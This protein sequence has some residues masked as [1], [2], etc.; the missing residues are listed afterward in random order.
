VKLAVVVQRYGHGING[1]AELHARYVAE[2]LSHHAE[3]D[4]LT[5][6]ASDYITWRNERGPASEQINGVP[7]RRF[8]V[9]HERDLLTFSRHSS[10]VFEQP[11]SLADELRW[12]DAEGPTSPSLVSHIAAHAITYDFCL[13]FSYRYYQAYHGAR[14]APGRAVLVP[15]AERDPAVGLGLFQPIFRGV[16]ALMYN[17]PEEQ[18][19]IQ[20]VSGNYEVPSVVVGVGSDVPADAQPDRFRQKYRIEGRFALYVGRIDE[21]KGCRE[22][23]EL[24]E[25]YLRGR[26][27]RLSLV[28]VGQTLLPI[29]DHPCIRHLGFLDDRD[30]FDAMAAA[31]LLIVPSYFESLSMV[32]LEAWA[33]GRPV[34]ANGRCDVLKGQIMRSQAGLYYESGE[35]FLAALRSL[36]KSERFRGVFGANGRKFF[37]QHY[38]WGVIERKYLDLLQRL[39]DEPARVAMDPLPGWFARQR[40]VLPAAQEVV[41]RLPRGVSMPRL[42]RELAASGSES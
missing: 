27:G 17:S 1:G 30:K 25:H 10:R 5:T 32:T 41:A 34:L 22:L 21:N 26:Y 6:F 15:T 33:L 39:A 23:F 18:L 31:D 40:R 11:H 29:P 35:E 36:E 13:F 24:F 2:H 19:M 16:R 3:V 38:D 42:D 4:V 7:V 14:A 37:G 20:T 28:L 9:E 8:P 12:L